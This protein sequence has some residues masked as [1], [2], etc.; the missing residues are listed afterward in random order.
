MSATTVKATGLT[1]N[2]CAM[3]VKE[4][5]SEIENVT[6]VEVEVVKDGESTVTIEHEGDLP[7]ESIAAAIEEAGF[8]LV[9]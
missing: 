1:C 2:H 5:V 9:R 8:E 4:E 6:G 3:S 7:T